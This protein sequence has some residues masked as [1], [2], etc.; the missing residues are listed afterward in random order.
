M[1]VIFYG[2]DK[3]QN[4]VGDTLKPI[5]PI[6]E[7]K[8]KGVSGMLS[9]C[10]ESQQHRIMVCSDIDLFDS[11]CPVPLQIEKLVHGIEQS[12]EL[13]DI[14]NNLSKITEIAHKH[15]NI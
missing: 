9:Y 3:I 4:H 7:I 10:H 15:P 8:N 11:W 13:S 1:K 14:I 2:L 5:S 12:V 6:V